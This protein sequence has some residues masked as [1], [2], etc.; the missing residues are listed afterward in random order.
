MLPF[1]IMNPY[2]NIIPQNDIIDIQVTGGNTTTVLLSTGD[3]Y[4]FGYNTY[5]ELGQGNTTTVST[6]TLLDTGVREYHRSTI[7]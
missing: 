7:Y 3:L 6:M 4:G 1:S 5:G 2:G